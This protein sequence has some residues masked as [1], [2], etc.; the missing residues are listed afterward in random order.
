MKV[1]YN[2]GTI[3]KSATSSSG[4]LLVCLLP[5]SIVI[6]SACST[7]RC[8]V[9]EKSKRQSRLYVPYKLCQK[10]SSHFSICSLVNAKLLQG[11]HC[12]LETLSRKRH[13]LP[14]Q[15][16]N[17]H[18]SPNTGLLNSRLVQRHA[19]VL[20]MVHF[21]KV[22]HFRTAKKFYVSESTIPNHLPPLKQC[23]Y[24]IA[25]HFLSSEPHLN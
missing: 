18:V 16:I 24:R 8:S 19:S 11:A 14:T 22:H 21:S 5:S 9:P 25:I 10:T 2:S 20:S 7:S 3:R 17:L 6:C 15:L 23:W 4:S 1:H 13:R 12:C